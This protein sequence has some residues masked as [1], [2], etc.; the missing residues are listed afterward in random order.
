MVR[1]EEMSMLDQ[2]ISMY[3]HTAFVPH[4]HP[5]LVCFL[6]PIVC[7]CETSNYNFY[8]AVT[9]SIPMY[10][11]HRVTWLPHS[12]FEPTCAYHKTP[13]KR[14]H[15]I[16]L[17]F[18]CFFSFFCRQLDLHIVLCWFQNSLGGYFIRKLPKL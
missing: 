16:K 7:K 3:Q 13:N 17:H 10:R 11:S 5:V 12:H 14:P 15:P 18:S 6:T 1:G 8:N 4:I 9:C 2:C